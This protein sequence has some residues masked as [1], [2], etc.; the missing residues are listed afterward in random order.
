MRKATES[1]PT[2]L[3]GRGGG[4]QRAYDSARGAMSA[5]MRGG[6]LQMS[7]ASSVR[8]VA[9]LA[10]IIALTCALAPQASA[11]VTV[12]IGQVRDAALKFVQ[13]KFDLSPQAA[14]HVMKQYEVRN[15]ASI[16]D[17]L[18]LPEGAV[19]DFVRL[20]GNA[21]PGEPMVTYEGSGIMRPARPEFYA[22][23]IKKALE[24]ASPEERARLMRA[25]GEAVRRGWFVQELTPEQRRNL[26]AYT[27]PGDK[28][29][30][31]KA[32][33]VIRVLVV[34]NNFPHWDDRS[35]SPSV[36]D[37]QDPDA[38]RNNPY[39]NPY[40]GTTGNGGTPAGPISTSTYQPGGLLT[41]A[42]DATGIPP[43]GTGGGT[44]N[45]PR[46][47]YV[48]D[49]H[50]GTSV[51]LKEDWYDFLYNR[52]PVNH[53]YSVTNFW[54]A[55]SHGKISIE[56]NRG[57]IVGPLESHHILDRVPLLGGP[58]NDFA[59]QPG[60]PVIRDLPDIGGWGLRGISADAGTDTFALLFYGPGGGV[61]GAQ[62]LDPDATT[63]AWTDL[64]YANSDVHR[65]AWDPR[66]VILK[67]SNFDADWQLRIFV[68]GV[69]VVSVTPNAG[70]DLASGQAAFGPG[71][72][73]VI[74]DNASLFT[75]ADVLQS[76][77]ANRLLSMCY[78]TH[79]H[80]AP[81]GAMGGQ[82]YQL[83]HTRNSA[84]RVDD[85]GGTVDN[86]RDHRDRPK[87]FDHS[88]IDHGMPNMGYFEGPDSNGGHVFGVWLG[89]TYQALADAGITPSGYNRSINLYPSDV[90]GGNDEGGTSGPWN[91][92]HVFIP[93]SSVVLPVNAGLY[94]AAHELGHTFGC[95]DLYDLD[96]YTNAGLR[97]QP[98]LFE[99]S[100]IGPY[101]VMAHG[102]TRLDA[103]H[104]VMLGYATPVAVIE[105]IICNSTGSAT[106]SVGNA[107]AGT[108]IVNGASVV[109]GR[110]KLTLA[111]PFS[112][113]GNLWV[114]S[115]TT[116]TL[117]FTILY[118]I[119]A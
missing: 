33:A 43:I 23:Y 16:I 97:P 45:H 63:P 77:V 9:I 49:G 101:S 8:F 102:G 80:V 1:L 75:S 12:E 35:P 41:P 40:V 93:N 107:S 38:A 108:Q 110:Q 39:V 51:D 79:D 65:D 36:Y 31:T 91:G 105:D 32:A 66:R 37:D 44:A 59:V 72:T 28:T 24:T 11:S 76:D 26:E 67:T 42:W 84:G 7:N 89:H 68:G 25:I 92:A 78:Y 46:I 56:G 114:N 83:L 10:T 106:V 4:G 71:Q 29:V 48:V 57:D 61:G 58:G 18:E 87:P 111:T 112:T 74:G 64:T 52:N 17:S 54:Y 15:G 115:S 99:C 2:R 98:L 34:L 113:T 13:E 90:A 116:D 95:A 103:W 85:I 73:A 117:Q 30:D 53:T 21:A 82:P 94:L 86:G 119:A 50:P 14:S 88:T 118:T 104:K 69:G 27:L 70:F 55:N 47:D 62:Y 96:F 22:A 19:M 6:K 60:S 3:Y 20:D 81:S 100:M 109:S 5:S